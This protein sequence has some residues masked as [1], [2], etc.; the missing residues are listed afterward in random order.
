LCICVDTFRIHYTVDNCRYL[1]FDTNLNCSSCGSGRY[2][3]AQLMAAAAR[4][5]AAVSVRQRRETRLV[6]GPAVRADFSRLNIF[7][8]GRWER[9]EGAGSQMGDT[10][11]LSLSETKMDNNTVNLPHIK[12]YDQGGEKIILNNF[13]ENIQHSIIINTQLQQSTII[14]NK[15]KVLFEIAK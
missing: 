7:L 4:G 5:A 2:R 9:G 10:N 8:N 1:G 11:N 6:S 3:L 13:S 14:N 15:K 12:I